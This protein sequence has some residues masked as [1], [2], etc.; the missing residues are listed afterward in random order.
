MSEKTSAETST[1]VRRFVDRHLA[2]LGAVLLV[3]VATLRV[4]FV[5]G[6][7][8]PTALAVLAIVDRTRLLTLSALTGLVFVISLIFIQPAFRRWLLAGNE[9]GTPFPTQIRTVILWFPVSVIVLTTFILPLLA[10]WFIGWIFHLV[11]HRWASSKA[12]RAGAQPPKKNAPLF[13]GELQQLDNCHLTV[14]QTHFPS[15]TDVLRR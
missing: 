9:D 4:R 1:P 8:M 10:G 11:I 14:Q 15:V 3:V 5:A 13:R 6:F 7:D 2:L 12:V